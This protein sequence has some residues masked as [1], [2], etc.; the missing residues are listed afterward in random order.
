MVHWDWF[1]GE[2]K[3]ADM[4]KGARLLAPNV[5]CKEELSRLYKLDSIHLPVPVDTERL[6]FRERA[7]AETFVSIYGYGGMQNRR[8]IQEVVE[9][10]KLMGQQPPKLI[11]KAQKP[12]EE[13]TVKGVTPSRMI[14]VQLGNLPEPADL[15]ATG[16]VALQ[17][18]RYE[19]VGVSL[20]EAQACGMP[21]IAV[22]APPMNEIAPDLK[23]QVAKVDCV[24]LMGKTI[25]SYIPAASHIAS[26]VGS[27]RGKDIKELSKRARERAVSQFS[28]SVLRQ[29]W[30][31]VLGGR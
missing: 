25:A 31:D 3:H 4:W 1:S 16:D 23:V 17:P 26:V 20:I 10:W 2:A 22:D 8:S 24:S 19:G 18:S 30:M 21:V 5:M 14:E 12:V 7:T 11:I 6:V 27:I 15:Y 29:R 28:W 9:A 13:F